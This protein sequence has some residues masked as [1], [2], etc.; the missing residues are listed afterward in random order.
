MDR[1]NEKCSCTRESGGRK[2]IAVTDKEEEKKLAVP[3]DKKELS[4]EGCSRK[5]GK[6][7]EGS[8]QKIL[9]DR[10]HHDKLTV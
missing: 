5:N 10:Q 1:Q 9:A 6:R 4:A 2:N 3:L 8:R 7:E